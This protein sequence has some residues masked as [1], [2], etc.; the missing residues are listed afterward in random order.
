MRSNYKLNIALTCTKLESQR[1]S[2][3]RSRRESFKK[4]IWS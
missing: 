2:T 4:G 3:K 1:S